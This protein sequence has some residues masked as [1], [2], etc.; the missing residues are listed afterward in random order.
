MDITQNELLGLDDTR[1]PAPS[2]EKPITKPQVGMLIAAGEESRDAI[3][4]YAYHD[5][6]D[7]FLSP[8]ELMSYS[9]YALT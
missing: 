6:E 1:H 9:P 7:V 8:E 2:D 5:T 3:E 4:M